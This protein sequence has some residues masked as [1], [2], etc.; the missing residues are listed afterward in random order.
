MGETHAA[1]KV[2]SDTETGE[3]L[4][5]HVL[6]PDAGEIINLFALAIRNRLGAAELKSF[7]SAYP[8]AGSDI[9]HLL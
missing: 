7:V 5:A 6:A 9:A 2:I 8:T 3:I 4:G 1:A